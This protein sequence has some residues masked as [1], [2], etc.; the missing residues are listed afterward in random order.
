ML[1][2]KYCASGNDFLIFHSFIS[3]NRSEMAVR[4]CN[5]FH[6]IG[7]DGLVVLLP[8]SIAES[9]VE[10]SYKWEFY[11][12]DGS[13][14]NMCGNA[15]RAVS[16][17]AYHNNLASNRHNF[18]SKAGIITTEIQ[19][20]LNAQEAY[21]Q[22]KLGGYSIKGNFVEYRKNNVYE[23]ELIEI[24]IPHLVCLVS[25]MKDYYTLVADTQFLA[26]LRHKYNANVNIA[27]RDSHIT[28]YATYERGIE[29]VTQACGTGASAVYV[30]IGDF[31]QEGILVPPS[32]EKLKVSCID[33]EIYCSGIA[34]KICDCVIN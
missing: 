26:Q 17:Y 34:K 19:E 3:A 28:Y 4:L 13:V 32:K 20:I 25:S 21:I 12:S 24:T 16:L 14:A 15:S 9:N 5:R 6:G 22:S 2:S 27:F 29:A 1:L 33:N 23:F 7:A 11:N 8:L 30:C 10:A 18:L 31:A